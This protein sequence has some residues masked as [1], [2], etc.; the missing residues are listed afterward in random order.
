MELLV[1]VH[2]KLLTEEHKN[3]G[4]PAFIV[5]INYAND[6]GSPMIMSIITEDETWVHYYTLEQK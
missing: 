3:E 2:T 5:F 6:I 4:V 1:N